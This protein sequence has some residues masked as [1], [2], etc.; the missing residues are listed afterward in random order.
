MT[1]SDMTTALLQEDDSDRHKWRRTQAIQE[2]LSLPPIPRRPDAYVTDVK[3]KCSMCLDSGHLQKNSRAQPGE[4]DFGETI[5]CPRCNGGNDPSTLRRL[6]GLSEYEQQWRLTDLDTEGRPAV[7]LLE[8]ACRELIDG[9]RHILTL[10]GTSGN[11]KTLSLQV[12]VNE[13]NDRRVQAMYSTTKQLLDNLRAAYDKS[14]DESRAG[15]KR[16]LANLVDMP[17]LALDEFDKVSMTDFAME[18][19]TYLIDSR[20]RLSEA[21]THATLIAMNTDPAQ[22][23]PW[24]ASRLFAGCN[25]VV[26]LEGADLRP[27]VGLNE[28][29]GK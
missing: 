16:R 4:P 27:H 1:A 24:I 10:W 23:Q 7:Q 19:L 20:H 22:Q 26:H 8:K 12:V 2:M 17:Y 18:Q 6:S 15:L 29:P 5:P 25:R 28:T 13:M 9:R 11:G 3:P 21:G 14:P